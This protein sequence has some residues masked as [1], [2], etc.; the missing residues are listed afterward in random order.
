MADKKNKNLSVEFTP[1]EIMGIEVSKSG[2]YKYARAGIKKGENERI[3]VY[4]EWMGAGIPD[5]VMNL[6]GHMQA[7]KEEMD[8][9]IK[10]LE[11]EYK[12]F[13]ERI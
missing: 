5:F 6:M 3:S 13:K 9:Q 1:E 4:Y 2:D 10:N 7:N 8:T 12:E 11:G